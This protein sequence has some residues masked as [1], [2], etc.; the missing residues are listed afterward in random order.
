MRKQNFTK[1]VNI[2]VEESIYTRIKRITDEEQISIAEWFRRLIA[3][4]LNEKELSHPRNG[5][6]KHSKL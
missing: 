2:P 4:H 3:A 1:N 6:T 5:S